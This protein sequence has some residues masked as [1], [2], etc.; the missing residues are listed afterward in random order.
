MKATRIIVR[1]LAV[2][3]TLIFAVLCPAAVL[4]QDTVPQP[5]TALRED[6]SDGELNSF[7]KAN[8]KIMAIQV[9]GEQ[10][11]IKVIEDEG[12]TVDRF[13]EILEQQRDPHRGSETSTEELTSFNNAAQQILQENA[14][15]EKEMESSIHEEG[16][17][18]ET[19]KQILLA[20]Q[21]NPGVKDRV[22]KMLNNENGN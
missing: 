8:E 15:L 9:E 1:P 16:I 13:N 5:S 17:D 19:Y 7:V 21:Q 18:V 11:M 10:V 4:A 12:L 14:R 22:N 6:F 3:A 2:W 20:Y